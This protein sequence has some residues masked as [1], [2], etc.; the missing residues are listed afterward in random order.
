M[1]VADL[2]LATRTFEARYDAR[3][4]IFDRA[5][6]IW[7]AVQRAY[8][9]LKLIHA[10]PLSVVGNLGNKCRMTIETERI[11]VEDFTHSQKH[12]EFAVICNDAIQIASSAVELSSLLRVGLRSIYRKGY[13]SA[14]E[15]SDVMLSFGLIKVPSGKHFG[16]EGRVTAPHYGIRWEGDN[17]GVTVNLHTPGR[18]ILVEP[19]LGVRKY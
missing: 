19:P 5:G 17:Y 11:A 15:T 13:D 18:R 8:P 16:I 6:E 9:S 7:N 1:R 3:F 14:K 4:L 12:E 2:K 10:G